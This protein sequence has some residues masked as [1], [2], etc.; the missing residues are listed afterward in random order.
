M[1]L[2]ISGH[3]SGHGLHVLKTNVRTRLIMSGH[4]LKQGVHLPYLVLTCLQTCLDHEPSLAVMLE[5]GDYITCLD[6]VQTQECMCPDFK[7]ERLI[8]HET[9]IISTYAFYMSGRCHAKHMNFLFKGLILLI[10]F[11]SFKKKTFDNTQE[12][13]RDIVVYQVLNCLDIQG[14][15]G[16]SLEVHVL[17]VFGV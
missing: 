8:K 12:E 17:K 4:G 11:T 7:Y 3:V 15:W 16:V 10:S 5:H 9:L 2:V 1:F 14:T 6:V 13:L